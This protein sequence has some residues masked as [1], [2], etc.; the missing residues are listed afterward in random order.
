MSKQRQSGEHHLIVPTQKREYQGDDSAG[1]SNW[2]IILNRV[3]VY[4]SNNSLAA[5]C[6]LSHGTGT[7]RRYRGTLLYVQ[8]ARWY[9]HQLRLFT[10][11]E[12]GNHRILDSNKIFIWIL[13][14]SC[15][16][17]WTI[18][19]VFGSYQFYIADFK[20]LNHVP[21]ALNIWARKYNSNIFFLFQAINLKYLES[22][23][24]CCVDF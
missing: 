6:E 19:K 4:L 12:R 17:D 16:R 22:V 2:L 14:S 23:I 15:V 7:S 21:F 18:L 9:S 8:R 1:I 11:I 13:Q 20:G 24:L 3:Y 10:V 5:G